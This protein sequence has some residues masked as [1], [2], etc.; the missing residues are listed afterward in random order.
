MDFPNAVKTVFKKYATF[1]GRASRSEYWYFVLFVFL[2]VLVL[3]VIDNAI[4]PPTPGHKAQILTAIFQI[5]ILVPGL[6]VGAR[7]LHDTDRSGWWQLLNI[8]PVI[9]FIVLIVWFATKGQVDVN[10]YGPAPLAAITS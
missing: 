7:R 2:T 3:G 5:L 1:S 10:R 6:A 4:F 9:G 8:V